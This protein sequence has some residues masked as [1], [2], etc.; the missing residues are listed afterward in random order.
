MKIHYTRLHKGQQYI[1]T[2][3][4]EQTSQSDKVA[5]YRCL[6]CDYLFGNLSDLKRHLKIRHHIKVN[7]LDG[8]DHIPGDVQVVQYNGDQV[9]LDQTGETVETFSTVQPVQTTGNYV[10]PSQLDE[11][12]ASAVNILQQIIDMS[13]QGS[14]GAQQFTVQGED[15]QTQQITVR[16]QDGQLVTMNPETI[17]VQQEGDELLVTEGDTQLVDGNQQ[18][19][20]QYVTPQEAQINTDDLVEMTVQTD[21]I[22]TGQVIVPEPMEH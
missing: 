13:N 15:G 5:G 6:S 1:H 8:L 20:I 9:V 17:I 22:E 7:Q 4:T 11:K 18:F 16:S 14:I 21:P 3:E 19:V 10:V 2:A 12:T